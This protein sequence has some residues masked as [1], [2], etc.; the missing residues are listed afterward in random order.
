MLVIEDNQNNIESNANEVSYEKK[1]DSS[2]LTSLAK[3]PQSKV[4]NTDD[5]I[6]KYPVLKLDR[7]GEAITKLRQQLNISKKR[8]HNPKPNLKMI[9]I[10]KQM[11]LATADLMK[12]TDHRGGS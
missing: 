1:I 11:K 12:G 4:T 9:R 7:K 10:K 6:K 2:N 3:L 8:K 5:L